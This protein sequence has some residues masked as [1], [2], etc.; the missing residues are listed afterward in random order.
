MYKALQELI[1]IIKS[2]LIENKYKVDLTG[3][4][5]SITI[6]PISFF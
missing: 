4:K 1:G 3:F 6:D 5:L 2:I